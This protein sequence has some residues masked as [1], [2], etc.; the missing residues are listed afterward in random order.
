MI[1][2]P[3]CKINLGLNIVRKRVDGYHDLETV[4]YPVPVRDV[5]EV[6]TDDTGR[7]LKNTNV[8]FSTTGLPINGYEGKNLCIKAYELLK[9]DFP[10]LPSV[11]IFLHKAIPIG[12]GLGGGSA[13]GSFTLKLL[14]DKYQLQLSTEKLLDYALQLG[15]DCPF[16]ILN[17]SSFATGR[18]E[19]LRK[20]SLDLSNYSFV[21]VNPGIHI[22][23][24]WAFKQLTA[25]P[26]KV[27]IEQ[28]I[29]QPVSAWKGQLVNDFE[30]PVFDHHPELGRVKGILYENGAIYASLTGTGS[31]LYGIFAKDE[32]PKM[33]LPREY[34][35]IRCR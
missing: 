29:Q 30:K 5:L 9:S 1:S 27:S 23:T 20:I 3:N 28:V 14:N 6:I 16:F 24:P 13:D 18:G 19:F 35:V 4:F 12:A 2:F 15:S 17:Q 31:T 25:E 34:D 8:K 26:P 10:K 7:N 22:S 21:L 32:F 11:Q 33:V